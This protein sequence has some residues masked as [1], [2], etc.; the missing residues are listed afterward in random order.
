MDQAHRHRRSELILG[1]SGDVAK[2]FIQISKSNPR[3]LRLP[4]SPHSGYVTFLFV[5]NS[6]FDFL[7]EENESKFGRLYYSGG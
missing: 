4:D 2:F 1:K 7:G 5:I 6:F 3:G